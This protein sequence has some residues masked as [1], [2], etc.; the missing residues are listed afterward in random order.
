MALRIRYRSS[1]S[2]DS[3]AR[4]M[5]PVT[6]G[7]TR[8]TS[9]ANMN[10]ASSSSIS[11]CPRIA[12]LPVT[13]AC[14][15]Q[16]CRLTAR[17]NVV[18][19]FLAPYDGVHLILVTAQHPLR[20]GLLF[21]SRQGVARDASQVPA[22]AALGIAAVHAFHQH[23]QRARIAVVADAVRALRDAPGQPVVV[24]PVDGVADIAQRPPQFQFLL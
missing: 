2:A 7:A 15:I 23:V 12:D 22:L 6:I 4:W 8:P 3:L 17:S 16:R 19:I 20:L 21:R 5:P 13:V 11:V 10:S 9:S 24:E 1:F 14:P 18:D